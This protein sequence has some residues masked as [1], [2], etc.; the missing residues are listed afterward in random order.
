[1]DKIRKISVCIATTNRKE[2][3]EKCLTSLTNQTVPIY[4]VVLVDNSTN[5]TNISTYNKFKNLLNIK[6]F[7]EKKHGVANARNCL[8]KN[9]TGDIIAFIDDDAFAPIDWVEKIIYYHNKYH[10]CAVIVGESKSLSKN[11]YI[12]FYTTLLHKTLFKKNIIDDEI[13][14]TDTK[15]TSVK[16]DI[17]DYYQ[18]DFDNVF[19]TNGEDVDFAYRFLL[20]KQKIKYEKKITVYYNERDNLIDFLKQRFLRYEGIVA[21]MKWSQYGFAIN[22]KKK[23]EGTKKTYKSIRKNTFNKLLKKEN[24]TNKI[25][26][27]IINFIV[28]SIEKTRMFWYENTNKL[29]INYFKFLVNRLFF[30]KIYYFFWLL[31]NRFYKNKIVFVVLFK[32]DWANIEGIL[33]YIK[34]Y[35]IYPGSSDVKKFLDNNHI[36]YSDFIGFPTYVVSAQYLTQKFRLLQFKDDLFSALKIKQIKQIHIYHGIVNKNI[37][38]SYKYN[39]FYDLLLTPGNYQRKKIIESGIEKSKIKVV[40]YSKL[41]KYLFENEKINNINKKQLTILYAPTWGNI[42]TINLMVEKLVE[43][44][45]KYNLIV[46][47]H[48]LT[49]YY[50]IALLKKLNIWVYNDPNISNLFNTFDIMITDSSSTMFEGLVTKKPIIL[51]DMRR[52]ITKGPFPNSEDGPETVFRDVFLRVD[53]IEDLDNMIEYAINNI[54]I[55]KNNPKVNYVLQQ[56]FDLKKIPAGERTANEIYKFMKKNG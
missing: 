13:L 10:D 36:K 31:F 47:P 28:L 6:Y 15:N 55:N 37:G 43:L 18:I 4:E 27:I 2:L 50:M 16:K 56:L 12:E 33:P 44:N 23:D 1:M 29:I 48:T 34:N 19:L 17:L 3:L 42:S 39:S 5:S 24:Y 41:D 51:L 14:I 35:S 25:S 46:K 54:N 30:E 32:L 53:K 45:S 26:L 8:I 49:E 20:K 7:I 11:R 52:W 9:A 38:Y 22:N 21:H 40:G